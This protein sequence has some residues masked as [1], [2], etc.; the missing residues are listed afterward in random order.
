MYDIPFISWFS[1]EY[2]ETNQR[3][4]TLKNYKNRK[5]NTEDFIYSFSDVINVEFE[6]YDATRSIFNPKFIERPRW[7]RDTLN[8][9]T[10]KQ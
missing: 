3:I 7:I 9:D 2:L 1:K 4:D 10:W 8:Y 5:Y 6:G